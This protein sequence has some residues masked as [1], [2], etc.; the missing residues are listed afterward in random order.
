MKN[1]P[2]IKIDLNRM[3]SNGI[4]RGSLKRTEGILTLGDQVTLVDGEDRLPAHV[5]EIDP[6]NNRIL[7]ELQ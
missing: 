4:I 1:I 2:L 7:Y 6:T 3:N 5:A